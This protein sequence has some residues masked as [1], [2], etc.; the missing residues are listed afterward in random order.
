MEWRARPE[1]PA[2][3]RREGPTNRL[4]DVRQI[5]TGLEAD[6]PARR[7][8]DFFSGPGVAADAALARLHLEDTEPAKLD[9]LAALHGDSHRVEHRVD[10]H[11]GLDLGDIGDFRHFVDDVDFDHA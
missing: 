5:F 7:D 6:R 10:R 3:S 4:S 2:A 8:A 11:L 1:G 9:S